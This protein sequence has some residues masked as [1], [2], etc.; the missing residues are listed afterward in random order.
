MYLTIDPGIT[1]TGWAQWD[2][3]WNLK[4]WGVYKPRQ[5]STTKKEE[6][7]DF[8]KQKAPGLSKVWVEE[9]EFFQSKGGMVTARSGAL[10]KLTVLVGMII[11]ATGATP[12]KVRDWKGNLPKDV[13]IKRI[14][15]ITGQWFLSHDADAV[16]I[17][18][19]ISGRF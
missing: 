5:T 9:P 2:K 8:I 15:K 14:H 13:V 11:Q 4:R 18:L 3:D 12:I 7:V 19:Y 16:G 10:V 17:G 6:I 1:G